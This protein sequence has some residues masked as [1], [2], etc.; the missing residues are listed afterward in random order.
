MTL[1]RVVIFS[2]LSILICALFDTWS[3]RHG[4]R[5]KFWLWDFNNKYM[6]GPRIFGVPIEEYLFM[7][8][9]GM[10]F[11]LLWE[12]S[13][14]IVEFGFDKSS[15]III[16]T[17]VVWATLLFWLPKLSKPNRTPLDID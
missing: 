12:T 7:I 10:F 17:M 16:F 15:Y 14:K 13:G 4:R 5:D 3:T 2:L 9:A 11:A 1:G 8:F 6:L